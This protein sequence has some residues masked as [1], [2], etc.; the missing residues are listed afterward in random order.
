MVGRVEKVKRERDDGTIEEICRISHAVR[1]VCT[2][3]YG[4]CQRR[5][6][7]RGKPPH[8]SSGSFAHSVIFSAMRFRLSL[9][10]RTHQ[11]TQL[12]QQK[13]TWFRTAAKCNHGVTCVCACVHAWM[14]DSASDL[15]VTHC[16]TLVSKELIQHC[17]NLLGGKPA[18][19]VLAVGESS[20]YHSRKLTS[21]ERNDWFVR[22]SFNMSLIFSDQ[23]AVKIAYL[24]WFMIPKILL[25]S[26]ITVKTV[27]TL[28]WQSS[29]R[30]T[31]S[32]D[33]CDL[34]RV[35]VSLMTFQLIDF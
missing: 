29:Y 16:A 7:F 11:T 30:N 8:G 10:M 15:A 12:H 26:V 22:R 20:G 2:G 34:R 4:D 19:S 3:F 25:I 33:L 28:Y 6:R 21:V 31:T 23:T 13:T 1:A 32:T 14:T 18:L 17:R 9:L 27:L 35:S 5:R 24:S